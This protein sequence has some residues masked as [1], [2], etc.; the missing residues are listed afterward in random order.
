MSIRVALHHETSYRYDRLVAL[1]PQVI[2]LRPAPHCR[3]RIHSYS[4]QVTPKDHFCNWQQD[5][6]GNHMAR[7]VFPNKTRSLN[8]VVD[9]VAEMIAINPFDFFLESYAEKFPFEYEAWQ[10]R[11]LGPFL[12]KIEPTPKF[13][14]WLAN[15]DRSA[16]PT[17]DAIT[18]INHRLGNEPDEYPG[19][20][21]RASRRPRDSQLSEIGRAHV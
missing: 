4:L 13:S 18:E 11:E 7:Y 17:V 12:E 6:Q 16:R 8:V 1:G 2:R 20:E 19:A 14:S 9:L 5:P 15:V 21:G 3:T 10:L